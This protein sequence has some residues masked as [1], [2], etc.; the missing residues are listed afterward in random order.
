MKLT[1]VLHKVDKCRPVEMVVMISIAKLVRKKLSDI[2]N[3]QTHPKLNNQVEMPADKSCIEE[4]LKV[5]LFLF[6]LLVFEA[7]VTVIYIFFQPSWVSNAG[8]RCSDAT[9]SRKRVS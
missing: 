2:T 8:K 6:T 4:L 5:F 3:T 7:L 1:L 9:P